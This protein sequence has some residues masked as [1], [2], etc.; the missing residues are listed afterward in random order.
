MINPRAALVAAAIAIGPGLGL[1][2]STKPATL[3]VG[4]V[5]LTPASFF[6]EGN[7]AGITAR[8]DYRAIQRENGFL[9]FQATAFQSSLAIGG[10]CAS[11]GD[12]CTPRVYGQIPWAASMGA[13]L[14]I[15]VPARGFR[16][17]TAVGGG[18]A[19]GRLDPRDRFSQPSSFTSPEIH[20]RASASR[21]SWLIELEL[22][23]FTHVDQFHPNAWSLRVGRHW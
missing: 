20:V 15:D 4:A 16:L 18:V 9:A 17:T 11:I 7:F 21:G 12:P 23:Q 10:A 5:V 14:G 3:T 22:E 8:F 6:H 2:Q 13:D 19:I 1:G